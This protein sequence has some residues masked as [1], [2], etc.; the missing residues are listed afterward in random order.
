MYAQE[1]SEWVFPTE[2]ARAHDASVTL[3]INGTFIIYTI[4]RQHSLVDHQSTRLPS[5]L[6]LLSL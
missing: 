6:C 4:H 2:K 1:Q 3:T 5:T